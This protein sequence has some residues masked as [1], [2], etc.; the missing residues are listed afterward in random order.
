MN[1]KP[2]RKVSARKILRTPRLPALSAWC[3]I[4]IV[5]PEASRMAVLIA[6]SPNAGMV[7]NGPPTAPGPLVGQVDS[8]PGHRNTL[9]VNRAPSPPSHGTDRWRA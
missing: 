9:V 1:A 2:S 6:G 7:S 4:V 5:T 8:K 3:A